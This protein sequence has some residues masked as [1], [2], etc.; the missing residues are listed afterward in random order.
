LPHNQNAFYFATNWLVRLRRSPGGEPGL[1]G[2]F[3]CLDR[4]LGLGSYPTALFNVQ[5]VPIV[6]WRRVH[7]RQAPT[8]ERMRCVGSSDASCVQATSIPGKQFCHA[9]LLD[10]MAMKNILIETHGNNIVVGM[11][12]TSYRVRYRRPNGGRQLV[13]YQLPKADDPSVAIT[14]AQFMTLAWRIATDKARKL[15]WIV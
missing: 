9:L 13:A 14:S 4:L 2:R 6:P 7:Q 15:G 8:R 1:L 12:G 11:P 10:A 5:A 3:S